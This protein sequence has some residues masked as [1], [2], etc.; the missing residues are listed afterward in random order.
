MLDGR[1][2]GVWGFAEDTEPL[3]KLF[4]FEEFE[5][6]VLREIYLKAQKTG[7]F[8]ADKNV[9]IKECDIMVLL[10]RR[11]AGGVMSALKGC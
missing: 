4:L 10:T 2:V 11:T 8:I 7:K 1:V 6:G 9:Q 5:G 3:V